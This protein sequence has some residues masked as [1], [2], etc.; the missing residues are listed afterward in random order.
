MRFVR[1][2]KYTITLAVVLVLVFIPLL[3]NAVDRR[4]D[5]RDHGGEYVRGVFWFEC[6]GDGR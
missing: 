5:C 3:V 1:R 6:V 2:W 4:A